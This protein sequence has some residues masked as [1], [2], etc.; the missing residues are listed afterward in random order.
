M[1]NPEPQVCPVVGTTNTVLPPSHPDVDLSRSGQT[2]PVVGAKTDHHHNLAKHPAVPISADSDASSCPALRKAVDEP[3][4]KKLD[5][6]VCPV[7]GTV[8]TVLPPN[9][10]STESKPD[11]AECSVTHAKVGHHKGKVVSHP[12]VPSGSAASCPVVGAKA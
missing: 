7:V 1:T 6:Q 12:D 9:H 8:T 2:C 11:S 10:P 3:E 4:A 5:E